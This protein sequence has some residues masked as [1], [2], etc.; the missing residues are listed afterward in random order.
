MSNSVDPEETAYYEPSQLD[1][2]C[3]QKPVIIARGSERVDIKI[4]LSFHMYIHL[5]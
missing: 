1:L 3:L 5:K 4:F 2:C